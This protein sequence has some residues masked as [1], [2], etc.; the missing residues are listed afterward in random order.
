MIAVIAVG[1]SLGCSSRAEKQVVT[2]ENS[3]L[4]PISILYGQFQSTNQNRPPANEAEF[5]KYLKT[6]GE[7]ILKQFGTDSEKVFVSERDGQPYVIF[8][9][10]SVPPSGVI[11]YEQNGVGGQRVVAYPFGS[12]G[13]V[14]ETKFQQLVPGAG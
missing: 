9:G 8:Y 11:A 2:S 14:D 4:K 13:L 5:K 7:S 1:A 10:K 12:V 3:N 6:A